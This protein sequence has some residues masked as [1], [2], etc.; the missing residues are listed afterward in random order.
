MDT[1]SSH[2]FLHPS[3]AEKLSLALTPI[4][5][6]RVYVGNDTFLLCSHVCRHTELIVQ[7]Q[8]F[9]VDL[10][11]LPIH[12]PTI[13]LGMTWLESLRQVTHDYVRKTMTFMQNNKAVTLTGIVSRPRC[14]SAQSLATCFSHASLLELYELMPTDCQLPSPD[15]LTDLQFPADLPRQ[16]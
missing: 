12:G 10:H 3:I 15:T 13:I 8:T 16:S 5:P 7:E 1:G 11:I 4:R 2:D 14:I 6:F 9:H